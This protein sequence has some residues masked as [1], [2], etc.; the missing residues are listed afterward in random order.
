MNL[1][2][3]YHVSVVLHP[4]S[5]FSLY[6]G[7]YYD[8]NCNKDDINHAVLAVGYGVTPKGKKYWIVKNR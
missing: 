4:F 5:S 2:H 6:L 7:V 1:Y 8:R 3:I